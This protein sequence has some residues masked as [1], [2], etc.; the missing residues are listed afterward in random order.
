MARIVADTP[1]GFDFGKRLVYDWRFREVAPGRTDVKLD[2]FFQAK[3]FL[4][5]PIWDSVQAM[6]TTV[7]MRK[8]MERAQ[9][10]EALRASRAVTSEEG[11]SSQQ[12]PHDNAAPIAHAK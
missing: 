9:R 12:L 4:H 5:L 10:A 1:D 6:L 3:T 7:M 2:M 8:F 11:V